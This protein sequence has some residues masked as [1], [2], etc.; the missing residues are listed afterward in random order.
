[1]KILVIVDE[2]KVANILK[3]GLEQEGYSVDVA[4]DGDM[5][6][7]KATSS[8]YEVAIVDRDLAGKTKGLNIIDKMRGAKIHTPAL[9]LTGQGAASKNQNANVDDYLRKPFALS[10]LLLRI[11]RLTDAA[12]ANQKLMYKDIELDPVNYEV[13]RAGTPV[14]LTQREFTLLEYMMRNPG[15][16][17]T[18]DM[19]TAYVW[20]YATDILPNT[21]EVYMGY[22]RNKLEKPFGGDSL[23]RTRRGFGYIF[24]E[25]LG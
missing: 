16:V 11:R 19:I 12:E 10:E 4:Y 2:H 25:A 5:G 13:T 22:L 15:R 23:V 24:G 9:L 21:I 1:M 17:L 18:K 14:E 8:G 6:L 20:D 3:R 7:A